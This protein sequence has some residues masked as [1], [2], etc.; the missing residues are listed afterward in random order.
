MHTQEIVGYK[1]S[2]QQK[3]IWQLRSKSGNSACLLHCELGIRGRLDPEK[4]KE[5]LRAAALR[6][7]I[8]RTAFVQLPAMNLPLQV[9]GAE[10]DVE[11]N[12]CD[13]SHL[14]QDEASLARRH[15]IEAASAR[16]IN[17][18]K[19]PMLQAL[20]LN[21]A[22]DEQILLLTLPTMCA[23]RIS[24]LN[25]AGEISQIYAA[26][27]SQPADG[28]EPIQYADLSHWLNE[29]LESEESSPGKQFWK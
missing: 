10:P 2:P 25:L 23:D 3:H 16:N 1:L 13:L 8:L 5:A 6:H 12:V 22:V 26:N 27:A 18:E 9:V 7:E 15:A 4:L 21:E 28:D 20:L 19:G 17:Y 24:L 29:L 11:W 14:D